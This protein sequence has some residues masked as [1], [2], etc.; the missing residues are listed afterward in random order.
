[1]EAMMPRIFLILNNKLGNSV[2]LG[3]DLRLYQTGEKQ[4]ANSPLLEEG[5]PLVKS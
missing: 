3:I 1:M 5:R 4:A 2:T